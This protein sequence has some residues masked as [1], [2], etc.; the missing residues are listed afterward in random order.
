VFAVI[1]AL[2]MGPV[3]VLGAVSL[4]VAVPAASVNVAEADRWLGP[5]FVPDGRVTFHVVRTVCPGA[6]LANVDGDVAC[7]VHPLRAGGN[8]LHHSGVANRGDG[9]VAARVRDMRVREIDEGLVVVDRFDDVLGGHVLARPPRV[10]F[11]P[12]VVAGEVEALTRGAD[13]LV[14]LHRDVLDIWG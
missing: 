1:V 10:V 12:R 11:D 3:T 2:S 5:G 6:T 4:H 14:G 7:T 8:G 13:D 9:G